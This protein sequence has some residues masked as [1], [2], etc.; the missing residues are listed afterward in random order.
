MKYYEITKRGTWGNTTYKFNT[1]ENAINYIVNDNYNDYGPLYE[2]TMEIQENG[3][4]KENKVM[5]VRPRTA[6]EVQFNEQR[7]YLEK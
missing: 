3:M 7:P 1:V 4:I 5:V 6:R 2:V